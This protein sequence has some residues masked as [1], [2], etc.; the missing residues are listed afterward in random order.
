MRL[1][2]IK[3]LSRITKIKRSTLY[4]WASRRMIPCHKL[5]GLLRFDLDEVKEWVKSLKIAPEKVVFHPPRGI[6]EK[7]LDL[8]IKRAIASVKGEVY[9]AHQRENQTNRARKGG[10]NGTL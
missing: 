7:S 8:I 4:S 10:S 3:V 5:N 6:N 9:N 2:T 1:I